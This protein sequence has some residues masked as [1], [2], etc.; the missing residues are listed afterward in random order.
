MPPTGKPGTTAT[1]KTSTNALSELLKSEQYKKAYKAAVEAPVS[2]DAGGDLPAGI[3]FGVAKLT[4][5][6]VDKYKTGK[7]AGKFYMYLAGTVLGPK[8]VV[9]DGQTVRIE[10]KRT[11][12]TLPMCETKNSKGVVKSAEENI[13]VALAEIKKLMVEKPNDEETLDPSDPAQLG[14]I[15]P[16]LLDAAP[17]FGFRTW[18]G[19]P[20]ETYKNPRTNHVWQGLVSAE[21]AQA[22]VD[23]V[24]NSAVV[25]ETDSGDAGDSGEGD[26]SAAAGSGELDFDALGAA[27]DTDGDR[28]AM[29][30]LKQAATEAGWTDEQVDGVASWT[31]LAEALKAGSTPSD[32]A[33]AFDY[34]AAGEAA[35]GGDEEA[36]AK[37]IELCREVGFDENSVGTWAEVAA[38]IKPADDAGE[39]NPYEVG[40]TVQYKPIDPKTKKPQLKA[41]DCEITEVNEDYTV[42]S[43]KS[44]KDN[45]TFKNI[46][47]TKLEA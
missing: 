46:A 18:K 24:A 11:S 38:S 26:T 16:Q 15:I 8:T 13:A 43:L 47:V 20:T 5:L 29:A 22:A 39:P 25:D 32:D 44:L 1:A 6:K 21:D 33:A 31:E 40:N 4:D 37:L 45:K 17:V 12:K 14:L 3:D 36:Q 19:E 34:D 30:A 42:V 41:I 7:D 9:V 28:D 10:G 2:V 35:D 27:A 23:D